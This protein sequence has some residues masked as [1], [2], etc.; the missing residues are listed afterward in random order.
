[1]NK[2]C[3]MLIIINIFGCF[4]AVLDKVAGLILILRSIDTLIDIL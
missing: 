2:T 4:A 3:V 1:M